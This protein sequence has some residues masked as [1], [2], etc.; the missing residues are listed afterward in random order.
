MSFGLLLFVLVFGF[1]AM[2]RL[3]FKG[4]FDLLCRRLQRLC[5]LAKIICP[6]PFLVAASFG[7]ILCA[8]QIDSLIGRQSVVLFGCSRGPL[9]WQLLQRTNGSITE[10]TLARVAASRSCWFRAT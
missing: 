1:I 8:E 2:R 3:A 9:P 10:G 5:K 7:F 6:P 4:C